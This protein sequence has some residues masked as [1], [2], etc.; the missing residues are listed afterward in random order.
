[1]SD[2][3]P[4]QESNPVGVPEAAPP[5]VAC[6]RCRGTFE[7]SPDAC[8]HC[9]LTKAEAATLSSQ[10]TITSPLTAPTEPAPAEPPPPP[11]SA[12]V[13]DPP[14]KSRRWLL[15]VPL[16][17]LLLAGGYWWVSKGEDEKPAQEDACATF[18][19]ELL[20]VQGQD[21]PNSREERRAEGEVRGRAR[22]AGC[23]SDDLRSET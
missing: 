14:K 17:L 18:R 10:A 21:F 7:G 6:P 11:V 8:P 9:G 22:D 13:A 16:V 15:A 1:M 5:R 4:V 20:E 19:Q 3:E 2:H 23:D 12:E